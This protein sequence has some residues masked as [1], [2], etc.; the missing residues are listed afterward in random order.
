[1]LFC[2]LVYFLT[3]LSTSSRIDAFC[4]QTGGRIGGENLAVV[5][6]CICCS[7]LYHRCMFA[8]VVF[9]LVFR[10]H[11]ERLRNDYFVSGGT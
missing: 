10:Y 6:V 7:I 11:E 8:F 5:L 1:M 2:L 4:F 9:V 3:Y